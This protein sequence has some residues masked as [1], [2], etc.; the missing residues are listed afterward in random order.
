MRDILKVIVIMIAFTGN[1][2]AQVPSFH[3]AKKY[4]GI[5]GSIVCGSNDKVIFN[6]NQGEI[7]VR[8]LNPKGVQ[9]WESKF[10]G[11]YA[12][13]IDLDDLGN[14]Y[15]MGSFSGTFDFDP[16]PISNILTSV[17]WNVYISKL[18]I[19]GNYLMAARLGGP[20]E[21]Y[22]YSMDVDK[23]GNVYTTGSF[24]DTSDFDPSPFVYPLIAD[25]VFDWSQPPPPGENI[26]LFDVFISKLNTLGNFAWATHVGGKYGDRGRAICSNE[27]GN[28]YTMGYFEKTAQFDHNGDDPYL[29]T[30]I[31]DYDVFLRKSN[32]YGNFIWRRQ[33]D[34]S[35]IN[36]NRPMAV[37]SK[38]NIIFTGSFNGT[39][40]FDPGPGEMLLTSSGSE[41]AFILK[42]DPL[43]N[44]IWINQIGGTD[45]DNGYS[46]AI[47]R[48]DNILV[49]GSFKGIVDFDKSSSIFNLTSSN[50]AGFVTKLTDLGN[51]EWAVQLDFLNFYPFRGKYG[52]EAISI[53]IDT[54]DNVYI[55]GQFVGTKD[56]DSGP[57]EFF[58]TSEGNDF[59]VLKLGKPIESTDSIYLLVS[60]NAVTIG[61]EASNTTT[62]T[63]QSLG[64]DWT[65]S[66]SES[67][68]TASTL[69]G[70]GNATIFL[71]AQK[72]SFMSIRTATVTI[73]GTGVESKTITVTQ[74][75]TPAYLDI[76]SSTLQI[77]YQEGSTCTFN[78][79]SNTDWTLSCPENWMTLSKTSG[80]GDAEITLTTRANLYTTERTATITI[81]STTAS[82][83]T[84]T[85][86]QAG[87]PPFLETSVSSLPLSS[88]EGASGT[89][90][91]TS[92]TNWTALSSESWLVIS[93]TGTFGNATITVTAQKNPTINTRNASV[94]IKATDLPDKTVIINQVGAATAIT[95][96][97]N[98]HIK[99]YPNPANN[100]LFFEGISQSTQVSVYDQNGRLVISSNVKGNHI[101]ISTLTSSVYTIILFDDKEKYSF[102]FVKD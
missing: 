13:S 14:V 76:S 86:A 15:S 6:S 29:M 38:G 68:L 62:F 7:A 60:T 9:L 23:G 78:I 36:D 43:G 82:P 42:L 85:V 3:W 41:D 91:I 56:F 47:D 37:D 5:P 8:T 63:I 49:V 67:W 51:F 70:I 75:G 50:G 25:S 24:N 84:V 61:A 59:F 1:I 83:K 69:S 93:N 11:G 16:G 19:D 46:I 73:A 64:T 34:V 44:L 22:G 18:D 101:D 80:S 17:N 33:W 32:K 97:N 27:A 102:K 35:G 12:E 96:I 94:T 2:G 57:N 58:M 65:I 48:N 54:N 79:T 71:N 21:T 88:A 53:D 28:V 89:F 39:V 90:D 10:G 52:S 4:Y 81:T 31:G 66:S 95:E 40:D 30:A 26:A 55:M 72:N 74:E 92:N 99:I 45:F 98:N 77:G 87:A 100:Y 20:G